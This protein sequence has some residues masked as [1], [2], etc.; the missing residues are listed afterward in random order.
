MDTQRTFSDIAALSSTDTMRSQM[1][2][3]P[4]RPPE[5]RGLEAFYLREVMTDD[6]FM[7]E[8]FYF[9]GERSEKPSG[10]V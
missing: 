4:S 5:I 3:F 10:G 2:T 8:Q 7:F 6:G 1:T 9:P